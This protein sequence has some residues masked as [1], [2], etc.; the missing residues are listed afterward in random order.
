MMTL[1]IKGESKQKVRDDLYNF[2]VAGNFAKV[3]AV[4]QVRPN[5]IHVVYEPKKQ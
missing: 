5:Y 1:I 2:L 4:K 3:D